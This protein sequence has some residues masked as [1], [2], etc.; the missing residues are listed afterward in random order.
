M[1][2]QYSIWNVLPQNKEEF[3]TIIHR[4]LL[5][6]KSFL[7]IGGK[8]NISI[9]MYISGLLFNSI[10]KNK[11]NVL[12][13]KISKLRNFIGKKIHSEKKSILDF[14]ISD[15]ID[16]ISKLNLIVVEKELFHLKLSFSD[17]YYKKMKSG[18]TVSFNLWNLTSLRGVIAKM[19]FL[20]VLANDLRKENRYFN[21]N[22]IANRLN[23][24]IKEK[25]IVSIFKIK[26]ALNSLTNKGLIIFEG[27]NYKDFEKGLYRFNFKLNKILQ[28]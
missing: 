22:F 6:D 19:T 12:T 20:N 25:R 4:D 26:R 18:N 10:N 15:F 11:E 13:I 21:L 14:Y 17:A 5:R 24:N 23:L 2:K 27:Y 16:S 3:M 8:T 9:F 28:A 7:N 1:E